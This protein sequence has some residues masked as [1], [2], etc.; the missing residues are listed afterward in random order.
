MDRLDW[1]G[2]SPVVPGFAGASIST[3]DFWFETVLSF[4]LASLTHAAISSCDD[5]SCHKLGAII[6][7][8]FN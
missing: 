3:A 6:K 5:M 2:S 8:R 7:V 4:S 1:G